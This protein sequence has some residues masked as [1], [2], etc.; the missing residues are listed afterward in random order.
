MKKKYIIIIISAI[1]LLLVCVYII[2]KT[3]PIEKKGI[4]IVC[5]GDSIT[6]ASYP[7]NLEAIFHLKKL[8]R[9]IEVINRGIPGHTSGQ[10]LAYLQKSK[11]LD[12]TIINIV[13]LQLG[14]N[15]VRIDTDHTGTEQFYNNMRTII[16][17]FKSHTN[18]DLSHP[19]VFLSTIPPIVVEV[20]G[21]FNGESKRRVV[22]EIN[23]AIFQLG[24]ETHCPVLDN[25]ALFMQNPKLLPEIHPNDEGYRAIADNWYKMLKPFIAEMP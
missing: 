13:L 9:K 10:Y 2:R 8:G 18:S 19:E 25:Y 22:E 16:N 5:A 24:E 12:S 1:V 7:E 11:I 21:F 4:Y 17:L 20:P 14:T 6:A 3:S 15:D 23:P